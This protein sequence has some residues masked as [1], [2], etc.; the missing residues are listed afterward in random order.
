MSTTLFG[1]V[2]ATDDLAAR[3]EALENETAAGSPLIAKGDIYT[4]STG[5]TRLQAGIDGQIL[6][7]N[8][9][10]TTGLEWTSDI[11]L[12]PDLATDTK[13]LTLSGTNEITY[14]EDTVTLAGTQ[15]LT[16]KSLETANVRFVRSSTG[17]VIATNA[18]SVANNTT[19]TLNYQGTVDRTITFPDATGTVA[20]TSNIPGGIVTETGTQTLTNKTLASPAI[21]SPTLVSVFTDNTATPVGVNL[22]TNTVAVIDNLV[23][24]TATQTLANKSLFDQVTITPSPPFAAST[25]RLI[26]TDGGAP[27]TTTTIVPNQGA[28]ATLTLPGATGT[29]ALTSDIPSLASYVTLT[30]AQTLTNKTLTAPIISTISNTGTLTLPTSTDTLVGR[31][32][33]DTL[34]NKTLTLPTIA[35]INNGGTVTIPSGAGTF[36]TIAATQTLTNKTIDS[37]SNTIQVGGTAI[38]SI[39]SAANPLLAASS[40]TFASPAVTNLTAAS[41]V[42]AN[43]VL[44]NTI[45]ERTAS[46]GISSTSN[47]ALSYNSTAGNLTVNTP[48]ATAANMASAIGSIN[49]GFAATATYGSV[50]TISTPMVVTAALFPTAYWT[51]GAVTRQWGLWDN[52]GTLI[53]SDSITTASTSGIFYTKTLASPISL[54]AGTYVVGTEMFVGDGSSSAAATFSGDFSSVVGRTNVSGFSFPSSAGAANQLLGG[55]FA[56]RK[57]GSTLSVVNGTVSIPQAVTTP[58]GIL[59]LPSG[60]D[61]VVGRASVD[62]LANKTIQG[63][64]STGTTDS[65]LSGKVNR[66][67]W[68]AVTTDATVTPVVILDTPA[69]TTA[70]CYDTFA[71]AYIT[72]GANVNSCGSREVVSTIKN[73]AGVLTVGANSTLVSQNEAGLNG[74]AVTHTVTSGVRANVAGLAGQTVSWKGCTTVIS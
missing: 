39:I 27:G 46:A 70:N 20:L 32:T 9:G 14:R 23:N 72:A 24:T 30:G 6:V 8:S 19:V 22:S 73:V 34:T 42:T 25:G 33:T 53:A 63:L 52:V 68:T 26:L 57:L 65:T 29:I 2:G 16:N 12:T 35:S 60:P 17:A 58:A 64:V 7:A 37:A 44:A 62:T 50:F 15:T 54:A 49:I 4:Y 61:T 40:P 56:Y 11:K 31:A 21:S 66:Y 48:A 55:A 3:V 28:D 13:Y 18:N 59:T 67:Y 5:P 51:S 45:S 36:A 10:T 43:T 71:T 69:L 47:I 38:G 41:T 74:L 1:Y